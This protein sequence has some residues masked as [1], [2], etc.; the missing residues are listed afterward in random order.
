MIQRPAQLP[1]LVMCVQA[2]A[3]VE[4]TS[5]MRRAI[6][7]TWRSFARQQHRPN[8]SKASPLPAAHQPADDGEWCEPRHGLVTSASGRLRR[9]TMF[10]APR[11]AWPC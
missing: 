10:P 4:L 7:V 9:A 1:D 6:A 5:R 8:R 2:T 11:P 3:Q